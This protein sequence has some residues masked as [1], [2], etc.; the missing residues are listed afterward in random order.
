MCLMYMRM[1]THVQMHAQTTANSQ[2]ATAN[3]QLTTDNYCP[4][5]NC[6][7]TATDQLPSFQPSNLPTC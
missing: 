1:R 4:A 6:F 7:P 3:Y 5:T 2:W